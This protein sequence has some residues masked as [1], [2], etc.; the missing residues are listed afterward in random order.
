MLAENRTVL[1]E[2]IELGRRRQREQLV[3]ASGLGTGSQ[4]EVV[5]SMRARR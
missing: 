2:A 3:C 4:N 1:V 5:L